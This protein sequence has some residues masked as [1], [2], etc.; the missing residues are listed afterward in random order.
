MIDMNQIDEHDMTEICAC[1]MF[2]MNEK[3][4]KY[5]HDMIVMIESHVCKEKLHDCI[6]KKKWINLYHQLQK[7]ILNN[8]LNRYDNLS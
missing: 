1:D 3:K 7:S 2:D 4:E 6:K 5:E 8:K